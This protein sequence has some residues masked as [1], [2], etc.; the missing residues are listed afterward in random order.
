MIGEKPTFL[1]M[2]T[3]A[4]APH[5][6]YESCAEIVVDGL[7]AAQRSGWF[8]LHAFAVLPSAI[9]LVATPLEQDMMTAKEDFQAMT[10]P[11]LRMLLPEATQIWDQRFVV[12]WLDSQRAIDV[13]FD[14][15][16]DQIVLARP[17]SDPAVYPFAWL[18]PRFDAVIYPCF[19]FE[20]SPLPWSEH[21]STLRM[22]VHSGKRINKWR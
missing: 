2:P 22:P 4:D 18:H 3:H 10:D 5:L 21:T 6:T 17:G 7:T 20:S 14:A 19:G 13:Q 8:T 12:K 11:M 9:E 1:R 16:R 15:M